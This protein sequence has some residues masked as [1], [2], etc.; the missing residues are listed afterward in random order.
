MIGNILAFLKNPEVI[1]LIVGIPVLFRALAEFLTLIGKIIP[2]DDFAETSA[3][4]LRKAAA[5]II[6]V[7]KWLGIGSAK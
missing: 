2:G 5:F 4:W 6:K 3:G 1:A 7:C